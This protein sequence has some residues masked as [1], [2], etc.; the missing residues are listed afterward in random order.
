VDVAFRVILGRVAK[1]DQP[2]AWMVGGDGGK[3]LGGP[4][5][6]DGICWPGKKEDVEI[7]GLIVLK[8]RTLEPVEQDEPV[9]GASVLLNMRHHLAIAPLE[10]SIIGIVAV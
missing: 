3:V 9:A 8:E 4:G 7:V 10:K 6:R 2:E 5:V 1:A